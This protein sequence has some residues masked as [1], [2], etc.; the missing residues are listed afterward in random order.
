M[1]DMLQSNP[2]KITDQ[3]D[4]ENQEKSKTKGQS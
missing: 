4:T 2:N 3:S 1:G